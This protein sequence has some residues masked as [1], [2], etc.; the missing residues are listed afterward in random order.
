MSTKHVNVDWQQLA[1]D[2]R[3][4]GVPLRTASRRIGENTGFV[5]QLARGEV[6][7]PKFSQGMALLDLHVDVCGAEN[8]RALLK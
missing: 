7:E 4:A 8:T 5:S 1:L 2:I 6:R 3:H